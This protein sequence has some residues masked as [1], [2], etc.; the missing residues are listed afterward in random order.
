[1]SGLPKRN[2]ERHCNEIASMALE[3]LEGVKTF[4]IPHDVN[5][6]LNIR[7]GIHTGNKI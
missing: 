5:Q 6:K 7:I 1:M 3:I 2:G 4:Y